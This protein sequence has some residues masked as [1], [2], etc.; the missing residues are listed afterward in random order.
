M[1]KHILSRLTTT[2]LLSAGV[3]PAAGADAQLVSVLV[4]TYTSGASQG[5]YACDFN[6]ATGQL[7]EPKLA[8]TTKNP[9]FLALPPQGRFVYAVAEISDAGGKKGGAVAAFA[10][11]AA[12]GQLTPLNQQPSGGAGPCHVSVDQTGQCVLV[13]NYGSGSIAA[14]PIGADGRLGEAA[15]VIQHR[16]SSVNTNRQAGPHAHQIVTDPA[17]R[18]ALVCDLGLD[19][20]LVYRL[21]PARAKLTPNEPPF[22]TVAPGSGPRHLVFHP[23]GKLVFVLN[24]MAA[25]VTVFKWEAASGRLVEGE[26]VGTLPKDFSGAN[27]AAELA[28]HPSGRF[29]FA[30]NRGH[31]SV[32]VLAVN[33]ASGSLKVLQHQPTLGKAPRFIGLDLSGRW[34]LAANQSS[35]N[36]V[37]FPFAVDTGKL[38]AAAANLTVPIP[39]CLVFPGK[40]LAGSK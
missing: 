33:T 22:A 36:I 2:A 10:R 19:Q 1:T 21:D 11:D 15:T 8:A 6:P 34:L 32:A 31:N 16:G 28:M 35:D 27:S 17:N 3:L 13:A 39:V 25:T 29:L 4:G 38:G 26:T 18:F 37:V 23:D 12:T 7:G 20:I 9:A 14:L 40:N 24:E 5:I 30:S